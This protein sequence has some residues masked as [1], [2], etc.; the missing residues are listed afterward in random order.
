V[1]TDHYYQTDGRVTLD[2]FG[3]LWKVDY[4]GLTAGYFW[5]NAFNGYSVGIEC[6]V[7]F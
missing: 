6:S 3:R 7:K 5:C 4:I 1:D 2:V